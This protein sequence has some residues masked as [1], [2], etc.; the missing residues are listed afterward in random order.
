MQHSEV[1]VRKLAI[2]L[3]D[4]PCE[5]K[6]AQRLRWKVFFDE[7]GAQP[8]LGLEPG[9]D[10]DVYDAW[11]DH[12]LV[13]DEALEGASQ[14]VG[15]YRLLRE[16]RL[17]KGQPFYS[18]Q[19][20]DLTDIL[21]DT[22]MSGQLLEL[23]R[24]CVVPEYRTSATIALLWRGIA[25]YIAAHNIRL[26][27]GC[28]SF[29]GTDPAEHALGLSYLTHKH[30]APIGCRPRAKGAN[31]V[32]TDLL[33]SGTYDERTALMTLPPLVKGYL[34]SGAMIGEGAFVDHDFNTI[35]V[36][37]IMPVEQITGRYLSRFSAAA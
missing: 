12:L 15:T 25:E 7:M 26:M 5:V 8:P 10:L 20:F 16:A 11:C 1:P 29:H 37:I 23:G 28:A 27:L 18:A 24:A 32:S 35:D 14:I 33:R 4:T 22:C 6:A 31:A 19:E 34:R 21:S 9:L 13:L 2:R 30:L 3:A 36:C 17:P